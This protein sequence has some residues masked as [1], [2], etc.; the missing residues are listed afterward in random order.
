METINTECSDAFS[1]SSSTVSSIGESV[2]NGSIRFMPYKIVTGWSLGSNLLYT[3]NE[4]QFYRKNRSTKIGTAY[5]CVSCKSRVHLRNDKICIQ[6]EKYLVHNHKLPHKETK[7][8]EFEQ[9]KVLNIIKDKCS[10]IYTL[11]NQRKQSVRDIFYDVMS[12]YPLVELDF[13]RHEK[14][15]SNIRNQSLPKNPNTCDEISKIFERKDIIDLIG[16]TKTGEM[17]FNGVMESN[18]YNF[19]IFSSPRSI[20][21]FK[22]YVTFGKRTVIMDGTFAIVPIGL[23]IPNSNYIRRV[24]EKGTFVFLMLLFYY[25][26]LKI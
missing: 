22:K 5:L 4:K 16:T 11:L 1:S 8:E 19:C 26:S 3:I 23:N 7:E 10:D 20:K 14:T 12:K 9:L 21:L 2:E 6:E 13:F 25:F 18:E 15:L 24:Y 17:F